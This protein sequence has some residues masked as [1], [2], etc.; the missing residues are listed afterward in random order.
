MSNKRHYGI[1]LYHGLEA[2]Q[3]LIAY[4]DPFTKHGKAGDVLIAALEF[5]LAHKGLSVPQAG[6]LSRP[7]MLS[8]LP[9]Q[10]PLPLAAHEQPVSDVLLKAKRSFLK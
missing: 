10:Q 3:P 2:H 8:P 9:V 5:Y 1:Y 4:L 6:A 7:A